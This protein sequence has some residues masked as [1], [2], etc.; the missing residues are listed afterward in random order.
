MLLLLVATQHLIFI[1]FFAT[2]VGVIRFTRC[3]C[4]CCQSEWLQVPPSYLP[5]WRQLGFS[6]ASPAKTLAYAVLAPA[7]SA[8]VVAAFMR[9]RTHCLTV[10]V[11]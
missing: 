4:C 8:A 3:C 7:G 1:V 9:V 10:M 5:L 2:A 6:P 11:S